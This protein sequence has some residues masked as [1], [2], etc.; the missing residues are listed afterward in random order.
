M[1]RSAFLAKCKA[2]ARPCTSP[3][4]QIWLHILASWPEPARPSGCRLWRKLR[5]PSRWWR[6]VRHRRRTSPS[7]RRSR[8]RP[9]RPTPA[10]RWRRSRL[11]SPPRKARRAISAEAVVDRRTTCLSPFRRRRRLAERHLAQV[12]VVADAAHHEILANGCGL[13]SRR[14]CRRTA[15]PTSQPWR[16]AVI[17]RHVMPAFCL[18]MPGHGVAHDAQAQKS[19]LRHRYPP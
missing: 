5:S 17:D 19:H 1:S 18:E 3:A 7:A 11:S 13:G 6:R 2:S 8:R 15:P 4:M 14:P 16:R 12:V 9:G 10:H